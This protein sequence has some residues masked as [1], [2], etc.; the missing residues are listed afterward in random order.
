MGQEKIDR[1]LRIWRKCLKEDNWPG[2][3]NNISVIDPPAWASAKWEEKKQ[4]EE[5][6]DGL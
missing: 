2:Y 1:A 6:R 5:V 4:F 3:S